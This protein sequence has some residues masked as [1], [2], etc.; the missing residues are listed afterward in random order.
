MAKKLERDWTNDG[1][2]PHYENHDDLWLKAVEYFESVTTTTGIIRATI[3]GVT[4]HVGFASRSSW[5]DYAKRSDGFSY[6]VSKIK[7]I[8][9]EWYER[10]LH[11]YNWAGSAFALRNMDGGNWKDETHTNVM[12]TITEVKPQIIDTGHPLASNESEVKE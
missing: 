9:V 1:R 12:Q 6:T 8:V 2:P 4:N 11:G 3:S 10:N 7:M 5:D